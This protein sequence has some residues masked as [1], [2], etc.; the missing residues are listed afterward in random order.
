MAHDENNDCKVGDKVI[1]SETRPLSARK[2][3]TLDKIL[4]RATLTEKD[5]AVI[6]QEDTTEKKE[7]SKQEE[8]K[9]TKPKESPADEE[10]K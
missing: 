6:E 8:A 7:T 5:K 9:A 1:I 10:K 2:R 3:F 4:E